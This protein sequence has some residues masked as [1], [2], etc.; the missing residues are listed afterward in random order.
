M[1]GKFNKMTLINVYCSFY[2]GKQNCLCMKKIWNYRKNVILLKVHCVGWG[3]NINK[4]R[5]ILINWNEQ[6]IF[7]FIKE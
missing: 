6:T 5:K 2:E 1:A 4:K 7:F 3:R